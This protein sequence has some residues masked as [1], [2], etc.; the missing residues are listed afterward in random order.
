MRNLHCVTWAPNCEKMTEKVLKKLSF[1]QKNVKLCVRLS[2]L[3][4]KAP[5]KGNSSDPVTVFL[6]ELSSWFSIE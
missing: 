5:S 4:V 6:A 3:K 1:C 2:C